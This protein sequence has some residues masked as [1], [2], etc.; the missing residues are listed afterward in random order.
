[1][2]QL[3]G[4]PMQQVYDSLDGRSLARLRTVDKSLQ[5]FVNGQKTAHNRIASAA[6]DNVLNTVVDVFQ[7]NGRFD[8]SIYV[9]QVFGQEFDWLREIDKQLFKASAVIPGTK[10][11]GCKMILRSEASA[12]PNGTQRLAPYGG[13]DVIAKLRMKSPDVVYRIDLSEDDFCNGFIPLYSASAGLNVDAVNTILQ[14]P[15]R[16]DP[17]TFPSFRKSRKRDSGY[18]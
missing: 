10:T 18:L 15:S 8:L 14:S 9:T 3:E 1:M 2:Q 6:W 16:R 4:D 17:T 11:K 13:R 5:L 12:L 7:H